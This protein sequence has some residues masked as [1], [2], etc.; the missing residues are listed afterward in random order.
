M[1]TDFNIKIIFMFSTTSD[2]SCEKKSK[3]LLGIHAIRTHWI[4]KVNNNT[5]ST[6]K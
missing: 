5:Q 3:K 1:V 6:N 4:T 2:T